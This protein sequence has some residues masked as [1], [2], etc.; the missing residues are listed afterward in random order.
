M[1]FQDTFTIEV[2]APFS[3]ALS[4]QIFSGLDK[5][6]RSYNDGVYNQVL[7]LDNMLV[8]VKITQQGTT[9]K[10]KLTIELTASQ[11]ITAKTKA[12]AQ[13]TIE[14]IF[15]LNLDLNEF[16]HHI[17]NDAA[18]HKITSTLRGFKYPTTPTT[19]ESLVDSIVEQQISIKIA[20][21]IEERLAMRFG[22]NLQ[23]DDECFYA[24]PTPQ[25]I[26]VASIDDI[27]SCGL[28]QRKAEYIYGAAHRIVT[29]ELDLE[30]MKTSPDTDKIITELDGI[31]GIGVWTA[32]L[33]LFRGMQRLEVLPA[34]D[35]GIRRVISNYY[36][37]GQPIKA[38]QAREIGKAWDKWQGL[39]AFYLLS[40]EFNGVKV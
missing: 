3:L 19:F 9:R 26:D 22:D 40:A 37:N 35:F 36:C 28:S 6:V 10:P 15:N 20:R 17:E 31:K 14:Y 25:N 12:C 33:T 21:T 13:N 5:Q 29:G 1:A 24:F 8:L 2:L 18:M 32:E 38:P 7:N 23:L 30:S 11:P 34:D 27:K 39:A 16:Y 4:A